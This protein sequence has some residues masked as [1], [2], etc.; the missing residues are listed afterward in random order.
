ML[1]KNCYGL[2]AE[3]PIVGRYQVSVVSIVQ[4]VE[5]ALCLG[6][7]KAVQE[8]RAEQ[9]EMVSARLSSQ[10]QWVGKLPW[11]GAAK[12]IAVSHCRDNTRWLWLEMD[13]G[14]LGTGIMPTIGS[15]NSSSAAPSH[16]NFP[17]HWA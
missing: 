14:W 17:A 2:G 5:G 10:A 15:C 7:W 1:A 13:L 6:V 11:L 8:Q 4:G 3:F 16:G 12:E 9:R